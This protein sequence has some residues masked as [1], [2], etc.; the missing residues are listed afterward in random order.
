M[1]PEEF[2]KL[3]AKQRLKGQTRE[4]FRH[5]NKDKKVRC[6]ICSYLPVDKSELDWHRI[7]SLGEYSDD[8]TILLCKECHKKIH[9]LLK[10]GVDMKVAILMLTLDQEK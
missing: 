4:K 5:A 10:S 3:M 8:N 6:K 7:N 1:N 2:L 9:T